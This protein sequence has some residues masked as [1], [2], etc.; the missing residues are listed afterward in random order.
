MS[1]NAAPGGCGNGKDCG[2]KLGS[3]M[4]PA[5]F[6][7]GPPPPLTPAHFGGESIA[8]EMAPFVSPAVTP[9]PFDSLGPYASPEH[10]ASP[11]VGAGLPCE[12]VLEDILKSICSI[13]KLSNV[14]FK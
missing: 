5:P 8:V 12:L 1:Q 2:N 14:S 13:I 3:Y 11:L 10:F 4:K 9:E 6:Q 7:N